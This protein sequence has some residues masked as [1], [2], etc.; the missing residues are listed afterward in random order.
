MPGTRKIRV[1]R[2][3][4]V[5]AVNNGTILADVSHWNDLIDTLSTVLNTVGIAIGDTVDLVLAFVRQIAVAAYPELRGLAAMVPSGDFLKDLNARPRGQNEYLAIASNYEPDRPSAQGV[6]QGCRHGPA[7]RWRAQ[8]QHGPHRQRLRQHREGRLCDGRRAAPARRVEGRRARGLL[9]NARSQRPAHLL[10]RSRTAGARSVRDYGEFRLRIEPGAE[11]GTYRVECSGL[12]GDGAGGF[13]VPFTETELENFVLKVGRT[14]RGVRKIESPEMQLARKFGGQLFGAVMQGKTGELYRAAASE[15]R[16]TGQGLR[17]TLSLTDVPELGGIPWEYLYDDPNFLSIN[18]WTPVVR[19]LDLPKPRR[20]LETELPLR[21]LGVISAPLDAEPLDVEL[22]KAKLED[23]LKPLRE[24]NAVTIDWLEEPTL[25]ALTK[26]LRPDTYH[27]LHYIG[28]GGFDDANGEGALLFEDAAGRGRAVSGDQL[29]AVLYEKRSL[30]LVL[31]NSCEGA[32]NSVK[33]PFSGVAASLVQREVPAVIG[34]QFEITDRAAVL[35]ASEFY[36]MLAEGEPVDAAISEARLAIWAD[37][38]DVEWGTPVLFMRVADGR[39]FNVTHAKVL[40]RPDP[41]ALPSK[42]VPVADE[43]PPTVEE[44]PPLVVDAPPPVIDA[45]PPAVEEEPP[46]VV[47][48]APPVAKPPPP[49]VEQPPPPVV[50]QPPPPVAPQPTPPVVEKPQWPPPL[51][52]QEETAP[53][54]KPRRRVPWRKVAIGG[55]V[56][57]AVLTAIGLL[58]PDFTGSIQVSSAGP[59]TGFVLVSGSGFV[60]GEAVDISIDGT[61][62]GFAI[63]EPDGSIHAQLDVGAKTRGRVDAVGRM[64]SNQASSDFSVVGPAASATAQVDTGPVT[65]GDVKQIGPLAA[66]HSRYRVLQQRCGCNGDD[67]RGGLQHRSGHRR[68]RP[69]DVQHRG[70]QVSVL[71]AGPH[72]TD[73]QPQADAGP[74]RHLHSQ[75]RQLRAGAA[76]NGRHLGLE[77]EL[78]VRQLDHLCPRRPKGSRAVRDL[79][80]SAR[81]LGQPRD[82]QRDAAA[83]TGLVA[84]RAVPRGDGGRDRRRVRPLPHRR[85][86][87][88][89]GALHERPGPRPRPSVVTGRDDARVR[90]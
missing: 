19:Y 6:L 71:V 85:G 36:A 58:L 83:G 67:G 8:R 46:P 54:P 60:P 35:F 74:T 62:V 39:L 14:R 56:V 79:G 40:P 29:A 88:R 73:V 2:T 51:K 32:R 59:G 90:P 57:L 5:G 80:H 49:V 7:V 23:A 68:H 81:W 84:G 1:H 63:A 72:A 3:A 38:N 64:S 26:R 66:H 53:T 27:I 31:L 69:A 24:A 47:T 78:V 9:R 12:G 42:A 37:S 20:A 75:P 17:V 34:M 15:A 55:G 30:R 22:E 48:R 65:S 11:P 82:L 89:P 77:L 16:A 18:A 28:H 25:L 76:R 10:A 61:A 70:R 21:I 4:L 41:Q 87:H 45:A 33:D 43:A 52:D 86:W 50:E 13:T 44:A